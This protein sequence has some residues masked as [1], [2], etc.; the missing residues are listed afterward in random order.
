MNILVLCK[1]CSKN[2][3]THVNFPIEKRYYCACKKEL[4]LHATDVFKQKALLNQCPQCGCE[5]L[6]KQRDFNRTLGV[7]LIVV[8]VILSFYT[9]GISLLLV[10]LIDFILYRKVKNVGLCYQC[11]SQFRGTSIEHLPEFNLSYHDY[12][13]NKQEFASPSE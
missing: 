11:H 9:Y 2:S 8:G 13:K 7:L 10:T 3:E 5:H 4:F 1:S 12:Y 6:Y